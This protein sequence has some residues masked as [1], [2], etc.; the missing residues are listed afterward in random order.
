MHALGE[1][2]D[3]ITAIGEIDIVRARIDRCLSDVVALALERTRA[4]HDDR[5]RE[6]V[7]RAG[8]IVR[9]QIDAGAPDTGV[10]SGYAMNRV[11]IAAGRYD[12]G[13]AA[14]G[15]RPADAPAEITITSQYDYPHCAFFTRVP[16]FYRFIPL[17][18]SCGVHRAHLD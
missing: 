14:R 3:E 11:W 5:R 8:K 10:E 12:F 7:Q 13:A 17:A 6:I 18:A 15:E 1:I 4:V 9:A 16:V 2:R